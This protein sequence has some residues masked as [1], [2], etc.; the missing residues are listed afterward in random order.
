MSQM[1]ALP[2][3]LRK[4]DFPIPYPFVL[5][6]IIQIV[7]C[8]IN[9][10][11]SGRTS[12]PVG[13][14]AACRIFLIRRLTDFGRKQPFAN[15][16]KRPIADV[17]RS[18]RRLKRVI[19]ASCSQD[20]LQGVAFAVS[21]LT[22]R[23]QGTGER[24]NGTINCVPLTAIVRRTNWRKSFL[25]EEE[26]IWVIREKGIKAKGNNRKRPSLVQRKNEN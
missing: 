21:P 23:R 15:V 25:S 13:Y 1:P 4:I 3:A 8:A 2:V 24:A 19:N 22:P 11:S 7:I 10:R 9:K 17:R 12:R 5:A 14:R 6:G 26:Q 16:R 20:F 18:M